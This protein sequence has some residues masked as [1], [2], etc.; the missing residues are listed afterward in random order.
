MGVGGGDAPSSPLDPPMIYNIWLEPPLKLFEGNV[1]K[2]GVQQGSLLYMAILIFVI[3]M[4]FIVSYMH[5]NY[6]KAFSTI[7]KTTN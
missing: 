7:G 6:C 4:K 3:I 5:L 1:S 2:V